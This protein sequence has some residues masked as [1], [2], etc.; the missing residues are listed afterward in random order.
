MSKKEKQEIEDAKRGQGDR[1]AKT[2]PK[3]KKFDGPGSKV[4]K[5]GP[6]RRPDPPRAARSGAVGAAA[7]VSHGERNRA[8]V[9]HVHEERVLAA[10]AGERRRAKRCRPLKV[11]CHVGAAASIARD[12]PAHV[13]GSTA[14]HTSRHDHKISGRHGESRDEGLRRSGSY[15]AETA[16]CMVPDESVPKANAS[17]PP[18]L[19]S[20]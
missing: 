3:K 10:G 8:A 4:E 17:Y 14:V 20:V 11:A 9:A 6:A 19:E 13:V 15:P 1:M 16:H 12:A 5:V 7:A 2:G 18:A